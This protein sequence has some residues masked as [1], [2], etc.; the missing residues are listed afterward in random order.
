MYMAN[1]FS[2]IIF[3]IMEDEIIEVEK[4][5][6]FEEPYQNFLH[7][8]F[9]HG[10]QHCRFGL[11]KIDENRYDFLKI[12]KIYKDVTHVIKRSRSL[13]LLL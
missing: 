7:G 2:F 4:S 5:G 8:L 10:S 13:L 6:E 1:D 12:Y 3:H 11:V 9:F